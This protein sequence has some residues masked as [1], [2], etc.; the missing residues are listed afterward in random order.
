MVEKTKITLSS[1]ELE[2]VCNTD[3]I[4]TKQ[5]IIQKVYVLFGELA[6]PMQ[7]LLLEQADILPGEIKLN[8]P[9]I[10]KGENYLGLPYVMM[11]YPRHFKKEDT[12]AIRTMFWWGNFFSINLQLS[13]SSKE[14]FMPALLQRFSYLQQ[15]DYWICISNDQWHHHFEKDNYDPVSNYNIDDFRNVLNRKPFVKIARRIPLKQWNE[16]PAFLAQSFNEMIELLKT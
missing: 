14:F 3:W 8:G 16:V 5:V 2:L 15:N 6:I 1:K 7:Q 12:M 10:A 13:G 4:L 11:D 9:K